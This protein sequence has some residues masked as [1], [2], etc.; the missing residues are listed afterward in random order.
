MTEQ[1]AAGYSDTELVSMRLKIGREGMEQIVEIRSFLAV[2]DV[3]C[4]ARKNRFY[5]GLG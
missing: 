3:D 4:Y 2:H 5:M 1:V